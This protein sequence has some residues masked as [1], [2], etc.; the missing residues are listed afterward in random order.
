MILDPSDQEVKFKETYYCWNSPLR[1]WA[2]LVSQPDRED[3]RK[4]TC[5]RSRRWQSVGCFF[6]RGEIVTLEEGQSDPCS[7]DDGLD[8]CSTVHDE[9]SVDGISRAS[10]ID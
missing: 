10:E 6:D 2:Y 9:M 4:M 5:R 3:V 7:M 1:T 8:P